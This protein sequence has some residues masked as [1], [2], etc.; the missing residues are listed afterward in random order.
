MGKI[1]RNSIK[2]LFLEI[3]A[4]SIAGII[5]W[6][7]LDLL[8]RSFITH[9]PFNYSVFEYVVEP[10]IFGCFAGTVFWLF[11]KKKA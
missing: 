11:D 9:S 4:I 1:E 2:Y 6:P 5:L 3:I 7:L 8:Y 10:I